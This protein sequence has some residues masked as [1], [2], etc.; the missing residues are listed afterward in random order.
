MAS[1][2]H[3][4]SVWRR[5]RQATSSARPLLR[6]SAAVAL[7]LAFLAEPAAAADKIVFGLDYVPS[8]QH[9]PFYAAQE[10]GFFAANGLDVEMVRGYGSTDAVKRVA[11]GTVELGFGDAGAVILSRAEGQK[12][13][14]FTMI[15]GNAPYV[16]IVRRDAG[17]KS[18]QDLP[19]KTL[20]APIGS[21]SRTMFPMLAQKT[22]VDPASVNWLTTD[23]AN[24]LPILLANRAAGVGEFYA[25]HFTFL[26]KAAENN[27]AL[28]VIRYSDYGVKIYSNGLIA[29]DD[30]LRERPDV[31]RRFAKAIREGFAYTYAHPGE[32]AKVLAA[33]H[34]HLS[35]S[36]I[37][38]NIQSVKELNSTKENAVNGWGYIDRDAMLSTRDLVADV[39]KS[40]AARDIPVEDFYTN[41]FL[42]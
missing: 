2:D 15:Y 4:R 14:L 20:A 26:T 23:A 36:I 33:K 22:G 19:G 42:K 28:D 31:V 16:L 1:G 32:A 34:P 37:V 9:A 7:Y 17:I 29:R 35:P 10:K 40:P 12:V 24:L 41:D 11:A 13:K 3:G 8:G 27:L 21:A 6:Q 38:G 30:T 25:G 39:F 5:P 18:P